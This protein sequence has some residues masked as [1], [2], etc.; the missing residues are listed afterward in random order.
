M[1]NSASRTG[2]ASRVLTTHERRA[3][4]PEGARH[5]LGARSTNPSYIVWN[6]MKNSAMSSRNC[7]PRMRSA[8]V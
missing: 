8:T 4:V 6:R 7:E 1:K 2:A 3:P 5:G